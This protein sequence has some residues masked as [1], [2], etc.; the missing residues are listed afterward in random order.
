MITL[1]KVNSKILSLEELLPKVASWKKEGKVV[2]TNGCFDLLHLGH[3]D[4]LAKSADFGNKLIVGLNTDTSIQKIKGLDRPIHQQKSRQ[5]FLASLSFVDAVVLFDEDTPYNLIAQ[6]LPDVLV[7]G[8]DYTINQI[9]G[10]D[11]VMLNDGEVK[12]V[13]FLE[14]Y[15]S[16]SIIERIKNG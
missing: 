8:A 9:V 2:F 15:S 5:Q 12:T 1:N 11:V 3:L 4:Y 14:G 6:I 13:E 10:S 16:T 7:K